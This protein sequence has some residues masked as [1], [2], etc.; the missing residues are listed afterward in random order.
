MFLSY[1]HPS[2]FT[3]PALGRKEASGGPQ[4]HPSIVCAQQYERDSQ[5][6]RNNSTGLNNQATCTAA[7]R[8]GSKSV[9]GLPDVLDGATDG[10]ARSNG[11]DHCEACNTDV[12]S[13]R[14]TQH[15]HSERHLR[16]Q[17]ALDTR[18]ALDNA[19]RDK[20]G[21]TVSGGEDG[22][23]FGIVEIEDALA[24]STSQSLP[25]VIKNSNVNSH[26][27]LADLCLTSSTRRDT[28][29]TK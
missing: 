12:S 1:R 20:N 6:I 5:T 27:V 19:A 4:T 13:S 23:D 2:P 22:I 29:G 15:V 26:I 11:L 8:P 10:L 16:Q 3:Q 25:V 24:S 9:R 14:W 7:A 28:H 17:R 21:I 18:T